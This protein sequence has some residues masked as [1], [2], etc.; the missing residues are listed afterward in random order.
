[1][2][3]KKIL[4]ISGSLS[5]TSKSF[6][7]IEQSMKMGKKKGYE[8]ELLDLRTLELPFCDGR[9]LEE[10]PQKL[11]P[12]HE[13]VEAADFVVFGMPVYCYS[14]SGALKNFIDLFSRAFKNKR[15]GICAAAGSRMSYLATAD[16]IKI[17]GYESSAT[18]VQPM[19]LTDHN[20]FRDGEI[21]DESI[22]ERIERMLESLVDCR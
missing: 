5:P 19:V 7:L 6:L 12:I 18:G 8:T 2:K 21:V 3:L 4:H 1:M 17:L 9:K 16:L 14:I 15:F 22:P 20:D 13:Q 10:Y 11:E